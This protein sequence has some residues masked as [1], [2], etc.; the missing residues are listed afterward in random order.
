MSV[1][2]T[3]N[4]A[5]ANSPSL[6]LDSNSLPNVRIRVMKK[7][8]N[9]EMSSEEGHSL[10]GDTGLARA[11]DSSQAKKVMTISPLRRKRIAKPEKPRWQTAI[12]VLTKNLVLV[13]VLLG[14]WNMISK[15]VWKFEDSSV[16]APV[17]TLDFEGRISELEAFLKKTTNMMQVQ[18][19][20]VD[21]KI[22]SEV[23]S[24]RG[25][26]TKKVEEKGLRI[27]TEFKKLGFRTDN[28]EKSLHE[29]K[30]TGFLSK[31][32]FNELKM[33]KGLEGSDERFSLDETRVVAREIVEKEIERHAADGLGRVDYALA[34]SGAK[35]VRHSEPF[36]FEKGF[37][38]FRPAK[39]QNWVHLAAQKMLQPS[40]GEPGQC[41][42]LKGS[43]GFVEIKLRTAIIPEA[44]TLD[45][46]SKS[47]A[48]DRSSAPKD[49]RVSAWFQ[50]HSDDPSGQAKQM[51]K[52]V[53]FMYDLEKSNAQTFNVESADT[54]IVNIVRLDFASN[55]GS[56]SHT[57]IYRLRVHGYDPG[58][59]A[60]L[61]M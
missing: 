32:D 61:A 14:L 56:P 52:L 23:A 34:S 50:G 30:D 35:V 59:V 60:T 18:V 28:L 2:V 47:V 38:W 55:H 37:S 15:Q 19:D 51:F 57:C 43:N 20:V 26:V 5:G 36:Y 21:R 29:L 58:N 4:P 11:K 33:S 48:Y 10:R 42:P 39:I 17:A 54:G 16:V 1:A 25:E 3:A 53:E 44:L 46:V 7:S 22:E 13:L 31:E 8:A 24:L 12:S 9:V 27:E 41:F 40:F 45:H 49:C 6:A